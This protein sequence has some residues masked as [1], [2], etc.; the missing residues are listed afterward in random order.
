MDFL[1]KSPLT[2]QEE[3]QFTYNLTLRC[4][5]VIVVERQKVL[6]ILGVCL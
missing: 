6:K 1:F 4:V 2:L 3:K 5:T